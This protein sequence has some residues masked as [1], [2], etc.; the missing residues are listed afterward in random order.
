MTVRDDPAGLA[1]DSGATLIELAAGLAIVLMLLGGALGGV[2]SHQAQRRMHGERIL[3][4]AACRNTLE[5]LRSV[6]ILDLPTYDG[7]GFDVPG[8]N[9]QSLGLPP[10]EG[11]PDGLPGEIAVAQFLPAPPTAVLPGDAV[12]YR[13]TATVRWRGATRGGVFRMETLMGERR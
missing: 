4:M 6:N 1:R 3:A 12:V 2:A 11:D 7:R 13:V 5:T 9:G 10:L 8:Q